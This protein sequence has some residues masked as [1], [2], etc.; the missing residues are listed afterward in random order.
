MT[1][2]GSKEEMGWLDSYTGRP[3]F[4]CE[5]CPQADSCTAQAWSRAKCWAWSEEECRKRVL[6]HLLF[7]SH[8]KFSYKDVLFTAEDEAAGVEL[9]ESFVT[10]TEVAQN[11][12]VKQ[13]MNGS[14]RSHS[15]QRTSD[16]KR[17]QPCEPREPP[18]S[19]KRNRREN[20]QT[21]PIGEVAIQITDAVVNA[22]AQQGGLMPSVRRDSGE[23]VTLRVADLQQCMDALARAA[24]CAKHGQRLYHPTAGLKWIGFP[25]KIHIAKA[26]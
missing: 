12:I 25:L 8:H 24:Q 11:Q 14:A 21:P 13:E 16:S 15:Q 9:V 2:S 4:T 22:L 20:A 17:D 23:T 3:Y 7:S 10:E 18:S 26:S 5:A 1:A 19:F 6:H